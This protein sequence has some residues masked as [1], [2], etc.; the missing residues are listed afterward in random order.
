VPTVIGLAWASL[1]SLA[2]TRL[3]PLHSDPLA[4][5][6]APFSLLVIDVPLELLHG[7]FAALAG[8]D[9]LFVS[10]IALP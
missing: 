10:M 7:D 1:I 3:V 8:H 5:R 2:L 6:A 4:L 9:V